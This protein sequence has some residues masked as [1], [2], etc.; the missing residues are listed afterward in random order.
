MILLG[1]PLIALALLCMWLQWEAQLGSDLGAK[2]KAVGQKGI[3]PFW[4]VFIVKTYA[5]E[6]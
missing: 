1:W 4:T 5:L 6:E 2:L 3:F